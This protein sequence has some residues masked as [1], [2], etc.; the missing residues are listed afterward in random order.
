MTLMTFD[1]NIDFRAMVSWTCP[2]FV[3]ADCWQLL[4]VPFFV[5]FYEDGFQIKQMVRLFIEFE[6]MASSESGVYKS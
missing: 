1:N 3:L 2:E 4:C 5:F 6:K